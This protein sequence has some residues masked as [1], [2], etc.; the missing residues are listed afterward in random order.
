VILA[1]QEQSESLGPSRPEDSLD[2]KKEQE[3]SAIALLRKRR[4]STSVA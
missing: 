2:V 1:M 4:K 3:W